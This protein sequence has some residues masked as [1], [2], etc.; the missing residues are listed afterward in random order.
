MAWRE[1]APSLTI[2]TT[3]GIGQHSEAPPHTFILDLTRQAIDEE[4]LERLFENS[5]VPLREIKK[6]RTAM[7]S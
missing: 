3:Y 4:L 6:Y 5:R 1:N 2:T 7:Y